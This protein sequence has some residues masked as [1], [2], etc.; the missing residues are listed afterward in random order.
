RVC[1]SSR[2][3]PCGSEEPSDMPADTSI[4]NGTAPESPTTV[5]SRFD[6]P[7]FMVPKSIADIREMAR[8]IG[9]AEWAPESYRDLEGDYVQQKMELAIMHGATVGLG[10]IAA[11][12]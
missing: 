3:R 5:A 6:V 2:P 11:L 12:Q 8:L 9:L 4:V 1:G 7:E 10:P